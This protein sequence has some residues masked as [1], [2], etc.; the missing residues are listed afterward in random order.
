MK[1][2]VHVDL[3]DPE[4]AEAAEEIEAALRHA[5]DDASH[6]SITRA[7]SSALPRVVE[8]LRSAGD[9]RQTDERLSQIA[10]RD[11]GWAFGFIVCGT[12]TAL[13]KLALEHTAN[14]AP[15]C[16]RR[17]TVSAIMFEHVVSV[18]TTVS[19]QFSKAEQRRAAAA[20]VGAIAY[21]LTN[22][23]GVARCCVS[24]FRSPETV[25]AGAIL[26]SV[27]ISEHSETLIKLPEASELRKLAAQHQ[28]LLPGYEAVYIAEG[29]GWS[30]PFATKNVVCGGR[31]QL[32]RNVSVTS[33]AAMTGSVV[34]CT[35]DGAL[36]TLDT[37]CKET[38]ESFDLGDVVATSIDASAAT[39]QL[40][41]AV[42]GNDGASV[43]IISEAQDKPTWTQR[44][45]VTLADPAPKSVATA[46]RTLRTVPQLCVASCDSERSVVSLADL[47]TTK[48]LSM[49]QPHTDVITT[50]HAPAS[51]ESV[52]LSASRDK[53]V[54][55][56]DVRS[57]AK[58]A[59][60]AVHTQTVTSVSSE[61][62]VVIAAGLDGKVA[63]CDIRNLS[64][65][66]GRRTF[67][68]GV[69]RTALGPSHV[70]AVATVN[71]LHLMSLHASDMPIA[72]VDM[73]TTPC[74]DL[75]WVPGRGS[76]CVA[77]G[78][79]LEVIS[80]EALPSATQ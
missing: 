73:R 35:S 65:P 50:L 64:Q 79:T 43:A 44:G 61:G 33:V 45:T 68:S 25:P 56:F 80:C 29:M 52:L 57:N 46:V 14:L 17:R 5:V 66:V 6:V 37:S 34:A 55:L 3:L 42:T 74:S 40:V 41:V 20:L 48:V 78:P 75:A 4:D 63:V 24:L 77:A 76:L 54:A 62:D 16:E 32:P 39:R 30:P 71:S 69:L 7:A 58:V 27:L 38:A 31:H 47:T 10:S 13:R 49:L 15:A 60:M 70:C 36:L 28:Q 51:R 12:D 22:V 8:V 53:T 59:T 23:S 18:F 2:R 19:P 1:V 67:D 9:G 21:S 11:L 26:L 72:R